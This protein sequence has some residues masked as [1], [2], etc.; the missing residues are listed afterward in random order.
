MKFSQSRELKEFLQEKNI[1]P[2][3]LELREICKGGSSYNFLV[4]TAAVDYLLKLVPLQEEEAYNRLISILIKFNFVYVIKENVFSAY[5]MLALPYIHGR[6]LR[7]ADCT[8]EFISGLSAEHKRLQEI[9]LEPELIAPQQTASGLAEKTEMLF[10]KCRSLMSGLIYKYFWRRF[11]PQLR[12]QKKTDEIIHGDFTSNNIF[13][14]E[15]KNAHI[16]DVASLRYGYAGEDFAYLFLQL[17]GFRGLCGRVK[18]FQNLQRER[19][20]FGQKKITPEQWLY[21]VQMFYLNNLYRHLRN[22][23]KQTP[24]KEFCLFVSLM[25]YFRLKKA[26]F[27][28]VGDE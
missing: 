4:R 23:K 19:D 15:Q 11:K 14:D 21:G 18:R 1:F 27:K 5:R 10:K 7:Y 24:R 13:V 3:L 16:L 8:P 25:G 12:E 22:V 28:G 9:N 6:G 20:A 2:E 26:V 17:S